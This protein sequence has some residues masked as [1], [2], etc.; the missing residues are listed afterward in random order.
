MIDAAEAQADDQNDRQAERYGQIC[1]AAVNAQRHA[2]TADAFDDQQIGFLPGAL[3]RFFDRFKLNRDA[4]LGGCNMRGNGG[5]EAIG[6]DD[7]QRQRQV[8]GGA[9]ILDIL[10][11][12]GGIGAGSDRLEGSGFQ[13]PAA[14]LKALRLIRLVRLPS[15]I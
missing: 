2:K 4:F 14:W 1:T 11:A 6:I 8:A 15:P 7:F 10:V 5:F 12:P 3:Q 13:A 9:D